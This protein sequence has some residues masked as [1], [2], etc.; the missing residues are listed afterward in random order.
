[1]PTLDLTPDELLSTT[2]AVRKR[3]DLDRPLQLEIVRECLELAIQAP[4]GSNAQGWH[5]VVVTSAEKR[6]RLAE[7]YQKAFDAYRNMLV[8]V[9][10]LARR[11][12]VDKPQ[13]GRIVESAEYLA[14]NLERVPIHLIPCIEGRADAVSGS[15]AVLAQASQYGSIIPAT[16][17]FM[18]AAR[19]RGLGT[20]W[21][22]LHLMYEKEA[23]E[24]VGIP[25]DAVTQVALIPVAYARGTDFCP[26]RRKPL[27]AVL[28]VDRW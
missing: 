21:T 24:V 20:C 19:A 12:D 6:R 10:N 9:H 25:Y 2:R 11:D 27:D 1:M 15:R 22:T 23:A 3:L 4:T 16:W 14:A 26:A 8:S 28:H 7:L 13:M 5:F 18:L 17:S